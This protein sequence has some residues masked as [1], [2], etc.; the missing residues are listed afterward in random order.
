METVGQV[1]KTAREEQGYSIKEIALQ[2]N[3]GSK[4]LTAIEEDRYDVF[5][6]ETHILGFIRNYAHFLNVDSDALIDMYKRIILQETPAPLEQL[7]APSR[8]KINP[9]FFISIFALLLIVVLIVFITRNPKNNNT[10]LTNYDGTKTNS[11]HITRKNQ[12]GGG[13][14]I[15]KK[16]A[17]GE[18]Y[19]FT[20]ENNRKQLLFE[21]VSSN[22]VVLNLM[23]TRYKLKVKDKKLWDFNGDGFSELKVSIFSVDGNRIYAAVSMIPERIEKPKQVNKNDGNKNRGNSQTLKGKVILKSQERVE[24]NLSIAARGF[25]TVNIVKDN[26]QRSSHRLKKDSKISILAKNT[27]QVTASNPGNLTLNLNNVSLE[28]DTKSAVVGFLFKWRKSPDDGKYHLEYE[29]IQ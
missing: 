20:Y 24:I 15:T 26:S 10:D 8:A 21:S 18:V 27:I 13:K 1:L 3:M 12:T 17:I 2:T 22:V 19:G 16:F 23:N 6:S 28:I 14:E 25:A 11:R 4:Y 7:T 5:P 29:R 9:A